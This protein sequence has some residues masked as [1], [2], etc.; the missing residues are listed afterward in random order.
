MRIFIGLSE[1]ANMAATYADGF[2]AL[3]HETYT[4][5][6]T[7][8]RFYPDR[9]YDVVL[10]E[11][12]APP[13]G[14]DRARG[15]LRSRLSR[16][17]SRPI[18]LA[19]AVRRCDTFVFIF[20]TS[21]LPRY[22]DYP[23]LKL[24]G[25]RIVCVFCGSD[26]LYGPAYEQEM[27]AMG[28]AGD[29]GDVFDHYRGLP[30]NR[31]S[32]KLRRVRAA[33]RWADLVLSQPSMGQLQRRPYRRINLPMDLSRY[34]FAVH[35]RRVPKV[36]HAPSRRN[37]KGSRYVQ[38]AVDTLRS[39]GVELEFQCLEGVANEQVR[40]SL[41][42]ADIVIDQLMSQTVATFALEGLAAGNAVLARY[43]PEY[44][45]VPPGCPVVRTTAHTL[46]DRLREVI[47]DRG[48]RRRLAHAGRPY[49]E[50]HHDH[51][52]VAKQ[53]LDWLDRDGIQDCDFEPTFFEEG[54][55]PPSLRERWGEF[56]RCWRQR[57]SRV[58]GLA[59]PRRSAPPTDVA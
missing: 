40:A 26:I 3:G 34:R 54:F 16:L 41:S 6:R 21:F 45:R 25:K 36:L 5:V 32:M 38:E 47:V 28:L 46:V 52:V 18:V 10:D 49:V 37:I 17:V 8:H 19:R 51:R 29:L 59:S 56:V 14:Q 35:D 1:I 2:R 15:E 22:W 48:L 11:A 7:R 50:E 55:T 58:L 31:Y 27:R 39:E 44:A 42:E 24:L 57:F 33:E 9:D 23:L 43:E 20:G 12:W 4:A 30:Y 53:I 13:G